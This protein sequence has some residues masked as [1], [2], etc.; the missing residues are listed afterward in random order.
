MNRIRL[1]LLTREISLC[2][3]PSGTPYINLRRMPE[4]SVDGKRIILKLRVDR[5]NRWGGVTGLMGYELTP[6]KNI[7]F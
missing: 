6:A 7:L 1:S 4:F 3:Y 2:V 5:S